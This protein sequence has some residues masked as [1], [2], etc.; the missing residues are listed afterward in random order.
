MILQV[1]DGSAVP[2]YEQ[3]REQIEAMVLSGVIEKGF[4]LP[5]IRQL[6]SDLHLAPATV[7]RAYS[8]L[9]SAGIVQSRRG[10]GTSVVG[11]GRLLPAKKTEAELRKAAEAFA[12][13]A[14]QLGVSPRTASEMVKAAFATLAT[15]RDH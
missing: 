12:R 15:V 2:P 9:E 5:S 6:A 11:P 14:H 7:A 4:R 10:R 1:F 8:E 13:R 3:I